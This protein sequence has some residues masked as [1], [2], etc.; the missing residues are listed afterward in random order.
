M[1]Q[2]KVEGTDFYVDA[3]G[4]LSKNGILYSQKLV[5]I[6]NKVHNVDTLIANTLIENG[7]YDLLSKVE[8]D[9]Y[10]ITNPDGG[11]YYTL[12]LSQFAKQEGLAAST[13]STASRNKRAT[14]SGWFVE[15]L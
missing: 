10:R 3:L 9:V 11:V 6:K 14:K 13:L 4:R 1:E 15:K 12:S 8:R 7:R 5:R 2:Y